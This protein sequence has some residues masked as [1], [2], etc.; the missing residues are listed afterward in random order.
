[1]KGDFLRD[2]K[3]DLGEIFSQSD[4]D[5]HSVF[6][7]NII[8]VRVYEEYTKRFGIEQP[9][10]GKIRS[11]LDRTNLDQVTKEIM[12]NRLDY[13]LTKQDTLDWNHQVGIKR[14]RTFPNLN[15][16]DGDGNI[17]SWP[18]CDSRADLEKDHKF[19]YSLGGDSN[20]NNLQMLCAKCNL[21]KGNSVYSINSWPEG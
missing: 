12:T 19:P 9:S 15:I 16:K 6:T 17:C 2:L 1:M 14:S 10:F 5:L 13:W 18:G 11:I 8:T 3:Y 21:A 7:L 20:K 4:E